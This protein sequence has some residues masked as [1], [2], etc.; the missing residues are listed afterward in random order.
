MI[1]HWRKLVFHLWLVQSEHVLIFLITATT[2]NTRNT[3]TVFSLLKKPHA[4]YIFGL[5][6]GFLLSM[7]SNL[8]Q[9]KKSC[10][11]KLLFWF[12]QVIVFRV[13]FSFSKVKVNDTFIPLTLPF[14]LLPTCVSAQRWGIKGENLW[15]FKWLR[16]WS[17]D[18]N[19]S[20]TFTRQLII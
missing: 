20:Y 9:W 11:K 17:T 12:M 18:T 15:F 19:M 16:A 7:S 4:Y 2:S 10:G 5:L 8:M 6:C 13:I 3:L 1:F 14:F